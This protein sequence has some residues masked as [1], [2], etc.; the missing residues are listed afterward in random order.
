[1]SALNGLQSVGYIELSAQISKLVTG[2]QVLNAG[3]FRMFSV[4]LQVVNK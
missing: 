3:W 1:M 4:D 2:I